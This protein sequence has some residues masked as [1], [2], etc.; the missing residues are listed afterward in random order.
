MGDDSILGLSEIATF[1]GDAGMQIPQSAAGFG[2]SQS[3][4][5]LF[6]GGIDAPG[7]SSWDLLS[8]GLEEPLPSQDVIDDL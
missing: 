6:T 5:S 4:P 2:P 8:L 3:N 7:A 1:G